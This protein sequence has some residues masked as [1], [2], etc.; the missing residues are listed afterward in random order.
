MKNVV[1][2]SLMVFLLVGLAACS[3]MNQD[4]LA[5]SSDAI[6]NAK[7]PETKPDI[8]RPIRSDAIRI[9]S[10]EV[11][12]FKEEVAAELAIKVRTL[13]PE[14]V[15]EITILN[16]GNFPGAIFDRMTGTFSW[17]PPRGTV[18]NGLVQEYSLQIEA[19]GWPNVEGAV[20]FAR[21]EVKVLVQKIASEP[22][23]R[24]VRLSDQNFREGG[25][26]SIFFEV[27]D[28][29]GGSNPG[30]APSLA[31]S[32]IAGRASVAPFMAVNNVRGDVNTKRW[33]I[34]YRANLTGVELTD[35]K[36]DTVLEVRAQS[37]F[38]KVSQPVRTQIAVLTD[39][40]NETGTTY[41]DA[42]EFST[43]EKGIV[44]FTVFDPK[45]EAVVSIKGVRG[46]PVGANILCRDLRKS[47][48]NCRAEWQPETADADRSFNITI[49]VQ[50]RNKNGT[51]TRVVDRNV[52]LILRAI[53]PADPG[54]GGG[55]PPPLPL[56]G[57]KFGGN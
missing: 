3:D 54:G 11:V 17:T 5:N 19:I 35:S 39:F 48:I 38:G 40:V 45:G 23:V 44:P 56:P 43:A 1:T 14:Y 55:A 18:S 51:D 24:S 29:D 9:D 34:E 2:K 31:I 46:A 16:M 32:G 33:T 4:P 15:S 30:E 12:S 37:R 6:R 13:I 25:I 7:P 10:A 8:T 53:K 49:D 36:V 27:E 47:Y 22:I 50:Y 42:Y 21:K 41:D 20:L 28:Q 52:R 26:Y 57:P